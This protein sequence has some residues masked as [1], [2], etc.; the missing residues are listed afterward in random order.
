MN[1][2]TENGEAIKYADFKARIPGINLTFPSSAAAL[3]TPLFQVWSFRRKANRLIL[4]RS[5]IAGGA[6]L[7]DISTQGQFRPLPV[8][9]IFDILEPVC[10]SKISEITFLDTVRGLEFNEYPVV[11]SESGAGY[12]KKPKESEW[13]VPKKLNYGQVFNKKRKG[14]K[15]TVDV[16]DWGSECKQSIDKL[17]WFAWHEKGVQSGVS[18]CFTAD[19]F[20]KHR[21]C[22]YY[23]ERM[24]F[25]IFKYQVGEF[26]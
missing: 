24:N 8:F 6:R 18:L 21:M 3:S 9:E 15:P 23:Y 11:S 5:M 17:L 22:T 25:E 12:V 7:A 2:I 16:K 4:C 10:H 14:W 19:A 13:Y 1:V 26:G 20:R